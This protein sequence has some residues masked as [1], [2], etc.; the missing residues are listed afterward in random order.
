MLSNVKSM[1]LHG[2]EGYVVN[3]QVDVSA[4]IPYWEIVGLPD[5]SV[6]ESKERVRSAIKNSGYELQSRRIVVN[7]APANTKKEGSFF[8]LPIAIGVLICMGEIQNLDLENTVFIGELS[9]DGKINSVNGVLPMCI[10]AKKLGIKKVIIPNENAKEAAIINGIE[11]VGVERLQDV[12]FYLNKQLE[13]LPSKMNIEEIFTSENKYNLDFSE[14]KGQENIKRAL[15]IAAAGSHNC[16]LI[17]SPGSGKTMMAKRIPTILP[18]LTFEESLEITKIHSIAGILSKDIPLITSRPFRAPHHTISSSSLV[19]GGRIPK[20]GEISLAHYGVLFLDELPEFNKNVLEV[21]RGPLE[22]KN[23]SISRVNASLTYPCNFMFI[24]SMN[25]CPCGYYG[26][27]EKECNCTPQMISKYMNKISGPLLDRI[28]IQIEVTPVKYQKLNSE[29]TIETSKEIKERVNKAR[30]IQIERYKEEKIYSNSDLTPKLIE[31]YCR[32]D[33]ES[34]YI[35][36]AAFERLGLSA[37]AY[38]RIL[39]VARTIAD[40]QGK[41]NIDKTHIAEAIQY[42]SLDKKYWKN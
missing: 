15:E 34:N 12:V 25:P 2:L 19:G 24:A 42:R 31:K 37:R 1:S 18:D 30:K 4:G 3:V 11:V 27:K 9:L 38:G 23:I 33:K 29:D 32:L 13:I 14:V 5:I 17:G 35:L 6:R 16:L 40:L 20:P 36:Q 21:M 26:S 7:L 10:E 28:D 22:D 39:K 41:E 8:D